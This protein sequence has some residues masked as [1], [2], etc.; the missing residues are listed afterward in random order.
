M[1]ARTWLTIGRWPGDIDIAAA[2]AGQLVDNA[3]RHAEPFDD[4]NI[5]FRLIVTAGTHELLVE[6]DD[7]SHEFPGFATA[8]HPFREPTGLWW[9]ARHGGRL[10]WDVK[11]DTGGAVVGKTVQVILAT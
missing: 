7:A 11:R 1:Q 3:V 8:A 5:L 10:S 6:V 4:G 9:V 2:V